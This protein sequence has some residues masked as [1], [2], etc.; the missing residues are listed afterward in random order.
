MRCCSLAM[1]FDLLWELK[2]ISETVHKVF[3]C[4]TILTALTVHLGRGQALILIIFFLHQCSC[5][6][7]YQRIFLQND[8]NLTNNQSRH[9]ALQKRNSPSEY[10][11]HHHHH[12]RRRC[13]YC[14]YYYFFLWQPG[15]TSR[16][17]FNNNTHVHQGL[18]IRYSKLINFCEE[19][20]HF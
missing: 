7:V 12:R 2:I 17:L 8:K 20:P 15:K 18:Q 9:G 16:H 14:Y 19:T 10:Y 11:Y 5:L 6:Y 13:C 4:L 3:T 1:L